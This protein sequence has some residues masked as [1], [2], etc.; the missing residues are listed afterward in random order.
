MNRN[1]L[2][3]MFPALLG[4]WLCAAGNFLYGQSRPKPKMEKIKLA[5]VAHVDFE[6][7]DPC[8]K[9]IEKKFSCIDSNAV[10]V[11][12]WPGRNGSYS[13]KASFKIMYSDTYLYIRYQVEET[14]LRA[15]FAKDEG[16]RPWTDDCMELFILP[17]EETGV[18]Y[19]LEMNCIGRGMVGYGKDG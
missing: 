12:N 10:D 11:V 2:K 17:D 8:M 14:E 7:S 18:Y 19:N 16:S 5:T 1:I 3:I 9:E 6:C 13:P 4:L 15:T